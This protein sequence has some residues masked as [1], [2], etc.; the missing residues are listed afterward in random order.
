M[1]E[2]DPEPFRCILRD[3]MECANE[4]ARGMF[5][6]P[7]CEQMAH[8]QNQKFGYMETAVTCGMKT[9]LGE[10]GSDLCKENEQRF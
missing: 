1:E 10:W 6:T 5:R 4:A 2:T 8:G 9:A 7:S 3:H